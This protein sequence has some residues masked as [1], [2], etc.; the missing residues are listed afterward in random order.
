M[1]LEEMDLHPSSLIDALHN[2]G[3]VPSLSFLTYE[4]GPFMSQNIL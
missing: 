4:M 2:L 3:Q 1:G